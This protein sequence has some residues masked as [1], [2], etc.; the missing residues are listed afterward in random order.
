MM[1]ETQITT[2]IRWRYEPLLEWASGFEERVSEGAADTLVLAWAASLTISALLRLLLG[3]VLVVHLLRAVVGL[4]RVLTLLATALTLFA[5]VLWDALAQVAVDAWTTWLWTLGSF[6]RFAGRAIRG[7]WFWVVFATWTTDGPFLALFWLLL[8]QLAWEGFLWVW[9][10]FLACLVF[11]RDSWMWS[12]LAAPVW[13]LVGLLFAWLPRLGRDGGEALGVSPWVPVDGSGQPVFNLLGEVGEE[14]GPCEVR[15]TP[16]SSIHCSRLRRRAVWVRRL[17]CVLGGA[18]GGVGLFVR[19]RWLPDL[20]SPDLSAESNLALMHFRDGAK[21]LGGGSVL[22]RV[23]PRDAA[24]P[25]FVPS[26]PVVYLVVLL[27]DGSQE[28]FV[29]ELVGKLSTYA[30]L[31]ERDET[32]VSALRL[33]ALEWCKGAGLSGPVTYWAVLC[34]LKCSWE[35]SPQE[36]SLS[37]WIVPRLSASTPPVG[38]G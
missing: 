20:P 6:S 36:V 15:M 27:A 26:A 28:L 34:A 19:G 1:N 7:P 3:T 14:G 18:P 33:R 37:E 30:L 9:P 21:I 23:D 11:F 12:A 17:E 8:S 2:F 35:P 16:V 29:P 31:R 24:K 38:S 10:F 5:R 32:L 13:G 4:L 25:G 22:P